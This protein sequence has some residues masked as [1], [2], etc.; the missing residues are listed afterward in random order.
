MSSNSNTDNND[1]Y[2]W[3]DCRFVTNPAVH[4][5]LLN[6][7]RPN[8]KEYL[9]HFNFHRKSE[10]LDTT[11]FFV[12][13]HLN[14][15]INVIVAKL[16]VE[17]IT[18]EQ[19]IFYFYLKVQNAVYHKTILDLFSPQDNTN[20]LNDF[21]INIVKIIPR[22]MKES[23]FIDNLTYG[24][25]SIDV[26]FS[27]MNDIRNHD[28]MFYLFKDIHIK[29]EYFNLIGLLTVG[30]NKRESILSSEIW[31][32]SVDPPLRYVA[33]KAFKS[34][35]EWFTQKLTAISNAL[36]Y[37]EKPEPQTKHLKKE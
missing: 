26:I 12:S 6:S 9:N 24:K 15:P 25:Y 32:G 2:V 33:S 19:G 31:S 1:E 18:C 4:D 27:A 17:E 21:P 16:I 7:L 35:T 36:T 20:H 3:Y 37:T 13:L 8:F 34:T 10:Y 5:Y 14:D 30:K 29:S 23:S 22:R 11:L 28:Y